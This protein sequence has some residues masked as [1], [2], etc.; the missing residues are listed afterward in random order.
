MPLLRG[1]GC[2]NQKLFGFTCEFAKQGLAPLALLLTCS[3]ELNL[4]LPLQ[5]PAA[6]SHEGLMGFPLQACESESADKTLL[7]IFS[8]T[9]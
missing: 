6:V 5:F 1:L 4:L 2:Y 7:R 8:L 9:I 3:L